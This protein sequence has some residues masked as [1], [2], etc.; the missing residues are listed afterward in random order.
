MFGHV[1]V[2]AVPLEFGR[3]VMM[4]VHV[5]IDHRVVVAVPVELM[6]QCPRTLDGPG[7]R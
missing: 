6:W 1:V 2:V 4:V 3:R 7:G 5:K